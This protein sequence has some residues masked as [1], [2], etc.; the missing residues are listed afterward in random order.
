MTQGR[1]IRA[2]PQCALPGRGPREAPTVLTKLGK[3]YWFFTGVS[4]IWR[5]SLTSLTNSV[6][7]CGLANMREHGTF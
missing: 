1:P 5:P 2:L 7:I 6:S 3:A 4:L